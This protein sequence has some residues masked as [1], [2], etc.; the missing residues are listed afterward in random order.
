VRTSSETRSPVPAVAAAPGW[1]QGRV[2]VVDVDEAT[3]ETL[4]DA[5][6]AEG[7]AVEELRDG[8][9]LPA[10][11]RDGRFELV[12]LDITVPGLGGLEGCRRLRFESDVP[13]LIV[14]SRDSEADRVLGLEA[15]ADDYVGKPVSPAELISRVR[16]MLRRRQLDRGPLRSRLRAGD[17]EIDLIGHRVTVGGRAVSLTPMEFKLLVILAQA[18]GQAFSARALLRRLWETDYVGPANACKGHICNLRRKI[19]AD[20]AAPARI[21]TV[22]GAGYALRP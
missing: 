7:L 14:T 18:P 12:I 15:G 22:P 16:A 13:L 5:L 11:V 2:L 20:P 4:A 21:V 17:I 8:Q 1:M 9:A 6:G 19:E 10:A 3:T